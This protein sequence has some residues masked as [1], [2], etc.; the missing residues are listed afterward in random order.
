M[1]ILFSEKKTWSNSIDPDS[2]LCQ[3]PGLSHSLIHDSGFSR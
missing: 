2:K 1:T 3:F